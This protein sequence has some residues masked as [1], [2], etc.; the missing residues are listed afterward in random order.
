MTVSL[1]GASGTEKKSPQQGGPTM[2]QAFLLRDRN[3][4]HTLQTER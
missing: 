2:A 4:I 1:A 3:S